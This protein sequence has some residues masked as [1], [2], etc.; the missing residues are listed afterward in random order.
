LKNTPTERLQA[1]PLRL[2]AS[3]LSVSSFADLSAPHCSILLSQTD[4]P[5]LDDQSYPRRTA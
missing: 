2:F 3:C 5:P 4:R 1:R